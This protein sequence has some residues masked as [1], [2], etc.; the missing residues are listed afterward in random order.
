[1]EP[2]HITVGAGRNFDEYL[3][4]HLGG[5]PAGEWPVKKSACI[6]ERIVILVPSMHG[7]LRARGTIATEPYPFTWRNSN[8]YAVKVG[9]L[10]P[11]SPRIPIAVLQQS[12]PDWGWA[13]YA[14]SYTT[15]PPELLENFWR[16]VNSPPIAYDNAEPPERIPTVVSRIVRDTSTSN[17]LKSNYKFRCQ[18]CSITLPYGD[19]QHYIE[20]HHLRPL[21]SPHDGPDNESNMIV[22]CPNHHALFD[23]GVPR[24]INDKT[25]EIH[26]KTYKLTLNHKIAKTH[27]AYYTKVVRNGAA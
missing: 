7:D 1:M 25:V 4:R 15:V 8:R 21:G 2:T 9:N 13:G 27:M 16:L 24:F 19:N 23:L 5:K 18:I 11:I 20:V 6:G 14:R 12:F 26:G 22:L 10:Q 3:E 17:A